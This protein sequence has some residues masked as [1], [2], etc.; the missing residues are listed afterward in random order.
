M[1]GF[2]LLPEDSSSNFLTISGYKEHLKKSIKSFW[3]E[4]IQSQRYF[5]VL[6]S[7]Q[8]IPR[9]EQGDDIKE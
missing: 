7:M 8:T 4:S 5:K 2:H 6:S 3:P 9:L 1:L